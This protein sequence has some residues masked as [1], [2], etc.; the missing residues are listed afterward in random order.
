QVPNYSPRDVIEN[1][2]RRIRGQQF[3]EMQPWYNGFAGRIEKGFEGS[4]SVRGIVTRVD[5]TT[6]STKSLEVQT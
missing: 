4:Y 6:V 2:K 3:V 1:I 5:D